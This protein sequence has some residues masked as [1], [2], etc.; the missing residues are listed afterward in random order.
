MSAG[1]LGIGPN[2][3]GQ[4][5]F[6]LTEGGV[7]KPSYVSAHPS[8]ACPGIFTSAT[9]LQHDVEATPKGDAFVQQRNPYIAK[10]DA[11]LLIDSTDATGRCHDNG[12]LGA[13]NAP[14]GGLEI[15]D[16]TDV[17]QPKEIGLISHLGNAHTV[18]VD[19]KRPHIAFDVTQDGVTVCPN[20]K[21]NNEEPCP[22]NDPRP[23]QPSDALDGFEV[24]DMSS[25][26]NFPAGTTLQQKRDRCRPQVYRYR[27]PEARMATSHLYPNALQSCHETE[28]YPDD[29]LACASITATILFSL[30]GAFDDRG[31]PNDFTDD[32]PRGT[33]L[34]CKV[35]PSRT[36]VPA[37]ATGAMVTDCVS[38]EV[39]GQ[40]QSL[41]VREWLR[42][43]PSP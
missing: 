35:R 8:A 38:G 7:V 9:G 5:I 12:A 40:A 36:A 32:K 2:A 10:G 33:P 15:I 20:G 42:M 4:N 41:N 1:T 30:K 25:C 31:T 17:N 16:V 3:G 23:Q 43:Q 27:Y 28:I 13:A 21:R 34:P 18:N 19:P 22:S 26:M 37:F 11:Q 6:R 24:I 39:N 29:R 14:K